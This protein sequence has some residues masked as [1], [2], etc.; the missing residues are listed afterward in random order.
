MDTTTTPVMTC[1][2]LATRKVT[3]LQVG[4]AT[5]VLPEGTTNVNA[6]ERALRFVSFSTYTWGYAGPMDDSTMVIVRAAS[7]CSLAQW[8]KAQ[9]TLQKKLEKIERAL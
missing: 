6:P 8:Q 3:K 1:T 2:I 7:G 9:A 4:G 5:Y